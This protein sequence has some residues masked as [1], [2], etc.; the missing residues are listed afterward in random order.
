MTDGVARPLL[1][2]GVAGGVGTST[3]TRCVRLGTGL[4]VEDL[5]VYRGG[6][7]D[8]LVTSNTAA[9]TSRLGP[10]LAAC[11]RPPLLVVMSTV[12]GVVAESR[13]YLRKA[14]PHITARFDVAYQRKWSEMESP[15]GLRFPSNVKDVVEALRQFPAALHMMY[16]APARSAA[17]PPG[18]PQQELKPVPAG[19]STWNRSGGYFGPPSAGQPPAH[20]HGRHLA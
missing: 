15:P 17:I 13:S 8:V 19:V 5:G 16:A 2:A 9:A 20:R 12:P 4:P 18:V 1:V 6:L 10:A 3:W 7:V 11:P 14:D